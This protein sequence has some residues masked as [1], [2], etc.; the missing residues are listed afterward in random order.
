MH[1]PPRAARGA[2]CTSPPRG[3]AWVGLLTH[4]VPP[5]PSR[6]AGDKKIEEFTLE[7]ARACDV[8]FLA[9]AS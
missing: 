2:F 8:V 1:T 5:T 9:V 4:G 6:C 3:C 7:S